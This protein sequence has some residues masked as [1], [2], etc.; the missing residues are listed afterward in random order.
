MSRL[1]KTDLSTLDSIVAFPLDFNNLHKLYKHI[2]N[3]IGVLS[4]LLLKI[5]VLEHKSN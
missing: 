3:E 2:L 5:I 4:V 1:L